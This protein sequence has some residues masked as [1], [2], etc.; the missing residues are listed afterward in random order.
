MA[1]ALEPLLLPLAQVVFVSGN[2]LIMTLQV[3]WCHIQINIPPNQ[4][5]V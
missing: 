1:G 2:T 4:M 3:R 5:Q